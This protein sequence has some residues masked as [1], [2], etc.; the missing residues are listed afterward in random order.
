MYAF[1]SCNSVI[2]ASSILVFLFSY[3]LLV[4]VTYLW[5]DVFVFMSV[6]LLYKNYVPR[7]GDRE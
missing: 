4:K 5:V 6:I 2:S 1:S 7:D 3:R